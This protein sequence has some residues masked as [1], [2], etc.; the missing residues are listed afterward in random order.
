L[1][2]TIVLSRWPSFTRMPSDPGFHPAW[3]SSWRA[4]AGSF[5]YIC[6]TPFQYGQI[7]G[8]SGP[9][10]T[11]EIPNVTALTTASRLIA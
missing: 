1:T 9:W 7:D 2:L 5:P 8:L 10:A 11:V 3:S 4:L 6:S